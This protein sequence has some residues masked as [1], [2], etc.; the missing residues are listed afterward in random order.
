MVSVALTDGCYRFG[1]KPV[2]RESRM[3]IVCPNC[4]S[5]YQVD[6]STL[7]AAGRSVRCTRC[8]T[9]W[10]ESPAAEPPAPEQA[11]DAAVAAFENSAR[12]FVRSI[13][14]DAYGDEW[15]EKG[16][17]AATRKTAETRRQEEQ[18]TRWHT[19][20]G[21]DPINYTQLRDLVN[22]MQNQ[23]H[24]PLFEPYIRVTWARAVFDVVERSRNVI[25]HSGMLGEED[26]HRLGINIRDWVT[27]V[28]T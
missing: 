1:N 18:G 16:F 28:A 14:V 2:R 9:V 11:G 15:W 21:D 8:R 24:T 27:Q 10:F 12:A 19:Q 6:A 26:L 13:L 5:C 25:M 22:V 3:Q 4:D 7:G 20:R 17:S 23:N